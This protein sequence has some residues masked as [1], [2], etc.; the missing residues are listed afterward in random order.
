MSVTP[1]LDAQI[2]AI[3]L[4]FLQMIFSIL[5]AIVCYN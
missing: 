1:K 5:C 2:H 4:G 3:K